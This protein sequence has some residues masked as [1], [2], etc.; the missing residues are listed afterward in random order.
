MISRMLNQ[1][2]EC[3]ILEAQNIQEIQDHCSDSAVSLILVN[4][5]FEFSGQQGLELI[6]QLKSS[7]T[8]K[9]VPIML[10]SNFKDAQQ[11]A[12]AAGALDGF[13]KSSIGA[14]DTIN[15]IQSVLDS[16]H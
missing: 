10:V 11:A 2:F 13:G 6:A 8:T 1:H 14:P 7:D 16:A 3:Q 5:I 9:S 12:V 4:R 15:K